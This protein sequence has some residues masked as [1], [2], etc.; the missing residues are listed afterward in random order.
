VKRDRGQRRPERRTVWIV[1]DLHV[2]PGSRSV[3]RDGKTIDLPRLSFDLLLELIHAA[4]DA[5]PTD[6]LMDRVWQG[7]VVS[8]ATVA[9]RVELLRQALGDDSGDPRYIALVRSYGYRLVPEARREMSVPGGGSWQA[10]RGFRW[11]VAL[12]LLATIFVMAIAFVALPR[13]GP[14]FSSPERTIAVL[15]FESLTSLPGDQQFADGLAEEIAH[16][17][18][19]SRELRVAGR[20]SSLRFRG[21]DEGPVAIGESLGVAHLLEGSVRRSDDRLRVVVQL[22]DTIDGLQRWSDTWDRPLQDTLTIQRDIAERVAAQLKVAL[23]DGAILGD[24]PVTDDVE[25]FTLY[26]KAKSLMEYPFG[27]DLPR[28]QGLLEQA[29]A[30]DPEFSEAWAHLGV[31]HLRRTL[32]REPTYTLAPADS[33]AIARDA[34]DRALA[35][36]PRVGFA[37][38]GLAGIAWAFEDDI[39]KAARMTEQFTRFAPWELSGFSFA[40]DLFKSLGRLEQARLLEAHVLE[41]DPLCSYCRLAHFVTL[42]ALGDYKAAERQARLLLVTEPEVDLC[43]Y[44]LGKALLLGGK[45]EEALDV[46]ETIGDEGFRL[47]GR[48]MADYAL[49]RE[50]DSARQWAQLEARPPGTPGPY[51]LAQVAAWLGHDE[52]ALAL[53]ETWVDRHDLRLS[54]QVQYVDPVFNRLHDTP[55]WARLLDRI[56]RSPNQVR[57]V[58]FDVA[59][60]LEIDE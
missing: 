56:G 25:A 50:S 41:R 10:G 32:W 34:I 4:P 2:D 55:G 22:T 3:K 36:D 29:V 51:I 14:E 48:T 49:G 15:P 35:A 43:V 46:F 37:F 8:P 44:Q 33:L 16:V 21:S 17:L 59:P 12:A 11:R 24:E 19:S 31:A 18:A 27:S 40:A 47:A 28:A 52:R 5:L 58:E 1:D 39:A 42:T 30:L 23:S 54:F 9:K 7:V 60:F 45:A 6:V 13:P 53:L 57:L 20:S 38:G 26:L